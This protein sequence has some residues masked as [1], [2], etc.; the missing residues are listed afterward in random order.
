ML[1]NIQHFLVEIVFTS[2]GENTSWRAGTGDICVAL[3]HGVM[4]SVNRQAVEW[5]GPTS[6]GIVSLG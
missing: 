5:V 3:E 2:C 4:F 6:E 1:I